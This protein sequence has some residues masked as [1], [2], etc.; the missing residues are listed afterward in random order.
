MH[1]DRVVVVTGAGGGI[2]SLLAERFLAN[3]DTV[4]A[5][6]AVS[7]GLEALT[8]RHNADRLVTAVCDISSE[9]DVAQLVETVRERA[10][11]V[12]VLVNCA[13]FFPFVMFEEMTLAQWQKVIDINL[14]GTYLTTRGFLV[15]MKDNGWAGS[16]TS[17]R[18]RCSPALQ[19][20]PITWLPKRGSSASLA[21]SPESWAAT[22]SPSIRSRQASRS[23]RPSL[24]TSR[25]SSSRPSSSAS[26]QARPAG[27]RPGR[28]RV[29][30]RVTGL[31]LR[32]RS[33]PQRG[34]RQ[35]HALIPPPQRWARPGTGGVKPDGPTCHQEFLPTSAESNGLD[36]VATST[37]AVDN[38]P[39]LRSTAQ[40]TYRT[41][42][43]A[44]QNLR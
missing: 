7:A 41:A 10:G 30:S 18:G 6:D 11:R 32:D 36:V 25:L 8:G 44:P 39:T 38:V 28:A 17:H 29:L 20:N 2:G 26:P 40:S 37:P 24:I 33:D 34:R 4:I 27:D 31:G 15:L 13:G 5:T 21:R 43:R 19:G 3:G 42:A 16:S 23:Q 12:D 1:T 22:T 9:E 14:T 35:Q